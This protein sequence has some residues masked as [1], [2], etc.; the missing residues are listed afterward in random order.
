MAFIGQRPE[1]EHARHA[2]H[3]TANCMNRGLDAILQLKLGQ[4]AGDVVLDRV[5]AEAER[6][7]DLLVALTAGQPLEICNSRFVRAARTASA[8]SSLAAM[9]GMPR[10]RICARRSPA[11]GEEIT[12]SPA[13]NARTPSMIAPEPSPRWM[14]PD[15]PATIASSSRSRP[16]AAVSTR[17][18]DAGDS[19]EICSIAS[20]ADRS[21]KPRSIRTTSGRTSTT[22]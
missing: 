11:T 2:G 20:T 19:R 13:T 22:V 6:M 18:R 12:H 7:A 4:D 21:G 14:Q 9:S 17:M 5:L 3:A 10:S 15:A 8:A 16:F 1:H